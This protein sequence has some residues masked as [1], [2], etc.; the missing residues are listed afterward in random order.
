[1]PRI[2]TIM[3][4]TLLLAGISQSLGYSI[5]S[6]CFLAIFVFSAWLGFDWFGFGYF[7]LWPIKREEL[8]ESQKEQFDQL[9]YG[10]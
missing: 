3:A 1:M 10:K 9:T 7:E 6:I 2:S 5:I 8:T 4:P